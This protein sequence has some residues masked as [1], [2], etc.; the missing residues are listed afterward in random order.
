M[1]NNGF[2]SMVSIKFEI[3]INGKLIKRHY[4]TGASQSRVLFTLTILKACKVRLYWDAPNSNSGGYSLIRPG[5]DFFGT[6]VAFNFNNP[7][8]TR[9]HV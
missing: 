4:L 9:Y 8:N 7:N 1:I 6:G 2:K 5:R 3:S